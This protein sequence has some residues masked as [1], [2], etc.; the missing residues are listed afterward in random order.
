MKKII[1]L[2]LPLMVWAATPEELLKA[3][4][5]AEN[6]GSITEAIQNYRSAIKQKPKYGQA[7]F[8]LGKLYL[9]E[10]SIP[11]AIEA[12]TK[13]VKLKYDP[14]RS[15]LLLGQAY[16][17]GGQYT[18]A[19]LEFRVVLE[20]QPVSAEVQ[21][22]LGDV[23]LE[24]GLFELAYD[25]YQQALRIDPNF[26]LAHYGLGNALARQRKDEEALA[27]YDK[28]LSLDSTLALVHLA[29]ANLY[30]NQ[31]KFEPAIE[32]LKIYNQ[33]KPRDANGYFILARAYYGKSDVTNALEACRKARELGLTSEEFL[34]LYAHLAM[35]AKSYAEAL[36]IHQDL[37]K[38]FSADA[39]RY[40]DLAKSY[41]RTGLGTKDSAEALILFQGAT[42]NYN[43]AIN[44]DTSITS[45]IYFDLGL[46]YYSAGQYDSAVNAFSEKIR[47]E[48]DAA[49]AY[50]NR[51]LSH[52]QAKRYPAA[53][54]DLLKGLEI[55]PKHIQARVWL[56]DHYYFLKEYEKARQQYKKVLE[57]DPNNKD[58]KQGLKN[59]EIIT[60]PKPQYYYE[61][62]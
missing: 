23:Y 33:L 42:V 51:A 31:R 4:I 6:S 12:L 50:I 10:D 47:R 55:Q 32:E 35:S 60:K 17:R 48:P 24:K 13:A 7:Y 30:I 8:Q 18:E 46:A 5:V 52:S 38:L 3:G 41:Y 45:D 54:D 22:Y 61:D 19:E 27:E 2:V 37:V 11:Q 14:N 20:S 16:Y 56:A 26:A 49:G 57:I 25:A 21:T 39:Q 62:E 28:A 40:Y 34:N 58:A 59:I 43:R 1:L 9:Q 53:V 36:K 15:Y 44:L 29:R